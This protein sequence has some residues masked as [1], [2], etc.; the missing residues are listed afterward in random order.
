[1]VVIFVAA[2]LTGVVGSCED[3]I[4]RKEG[5]YR[6][7]LD[8]RCKSASFNRTLSPVFYYTVEIVKYEIKRGYA[9]F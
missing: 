4:G 6:S 9:L 2:G 7:Q 8:R 3:G 1:M 5:L